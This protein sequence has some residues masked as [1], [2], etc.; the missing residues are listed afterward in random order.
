MHVAVQESP[1][2]SCEKP[3]KQL[4]RL[5]NLAGP[6]SYFWMKS[7]LCVHV[8]TH[9]TNMRLELWLSCSLSWMEPPLKKVSRD[10]Q[11][12]MVSANEKRNE[13]QRKDYAT[14][15][16]FNEK[17]SILYWAAQVKKRPPITTRLPSV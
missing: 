9:S 17:P 16:Q 13:K 4:R 6:L 2:A 7:M 11:S 15:R 3:L 5:P 8:V 12:H 14:R 10:S 1:S